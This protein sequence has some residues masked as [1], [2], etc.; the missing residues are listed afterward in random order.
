MIDVISKLNKIDQMATDG[1]MGAPG[2]LAYRI[3]KVSH[4][5]ANW[6]RWMGVDTLTTEGIASTDSILPFVLVSGHDNY[7]DWTLI[8]G[9]KDTPVQ[10]PVYEK[11]SV[12]RI[13][14]VDADEY[15]AV[16]RLQIA[17]GTSGEAALAAGTY[18]DLVLMPLADSGQN[19]CLVM[20][21][22]TAAGTRCW[23]RCWVAGEDTKRVGL[24]YSILE[25]EG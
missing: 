16:T 10:G 7:G 25:Y 18:T 4:H 15:E 1:V 8:L 12:N 23:A 21:E 14:V 6:E 11:F 3:T 20:T 2:S 9:S 13:L 22:H 24:L 17:C 19:P 5:V